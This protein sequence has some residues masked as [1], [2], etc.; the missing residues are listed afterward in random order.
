MISYLKTKAK[1]AG[2]VAQMVEYLFTKCKALFRASSYS[3]R[4]SSKFHMAY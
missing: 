3:Y 2:D 4:K 1:R